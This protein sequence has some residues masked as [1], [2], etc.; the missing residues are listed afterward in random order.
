MNNRYIVY[1]HTNK[2][3]GKR[4]VGITSLDPNK[5]WKNGNGYYNNEHFYS[6]IKKYGWEEFSH[7]I[8]FTDLSEDEACKKEIELIA[9]WDLCNSKKGYNNSYGGKKG[10]MSEEAKN[11]YSQRQKGKGF[12]K[13]KN[14]PLEIRAKM[15][16][17]KKGKIPKSNPPK[18]VYC[19]ETKETYSSMTEAS[20][21]LGICIAMVSKLCH[22]KYVRKPK[23]HLY[24]IG[25]ENE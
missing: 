11:R 25:E 4:Y 13:G 12:W 16:K 8:L 14:I 18:I 17:A 23:Y 7:E 15:S 19:D 1:C 21:K 20:K 10:Q 22:K 24:F 3:N 6:A 2:I 9:K 5:R